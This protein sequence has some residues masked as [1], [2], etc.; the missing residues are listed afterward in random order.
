MSMELRG[1]STDE[2]ERSNQQLGTS[3]KEKAQNKGI[4]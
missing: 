1:N 3:A 4:V 2:K